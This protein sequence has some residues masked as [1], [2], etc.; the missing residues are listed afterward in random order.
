M[1]TPFNNNL[2]YDKIVSP[3]LKAISKKFCHWQGHRKV[4]EAEFESGKTEEKSE[5]KN[6]VT[7]VI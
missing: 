1:N 2:E 4:R 5:N 3:A 6:Q 7:P